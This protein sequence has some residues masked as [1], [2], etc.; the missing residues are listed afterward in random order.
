MLPLLSD[1]LRILF[2]NIQEKHD[3]GIVRDLL[4]AD[5]LINTINNVFIN[6]FRYQDD[7]YITAKN[8]LINH[9]NK[10][11]NEEARMLSFRHNAFEIS[12]LPKG[13]E[14]I[15][16]DNNT[17]SR[18]NRQT[19]KPARLI[20][21]LLVNEYKCKDFEDFSNWI[22]AEMI[23]AGEFKLVTGHDI[24]KYYLDE[25]YV[26]CDGTLGNS[27]MRHSECQ[28]YFGVYEDN[29]KMLVCMKN[30]KILGRAIVWEVNDNVFMDRVYT[31]MDY[32]TNQ[33]F[34]YARA[35]KW[36]YRKNNNLL[37][38]GEYQTW[39][40]PE[41]NYES[42]KTWDLTIQLPT[43]YDF[44]PYVDSFR[45]YNLNNNT[46][47]T[48]P[49]KGNIYLSSTE[50]TY[51]NVCDTFECARCG[52]IYRAPEDESPDEMVYSEFN[53]AWYC[54]DCAVYCNGIDDY[55]SC[56]DIIVD[57]YVDR[58]N[59]EVFPLCVVNDE[60]DR[61]VCI[62]D[63]WYCLDTCDFIEYNEKTNEYIIKDE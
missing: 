30:D 54:N 36:H 37:S 33:F 52:R 61:F 29:A 4:E 55:V 7:L 46:I 48:N 50:G 41:D 1:G 38:D 49:D 63:T 43:R 5:D 2:K 47:N 42:Y 14:A 23:N 59:T 28:E 17:W 40:G 31:C 32:L 35:N 57:V 12:Y 6:S 11:I 56:D 13:K 58:N 44:M 19:A 20:Q 3:C 8:V 51:D 26:S 24:T 18:E 16:S 21:K 27:C 45:Y 34:D 53:D 22:K 10:L 9:I 60:L 62:N 15:Y 25:N 39:Y